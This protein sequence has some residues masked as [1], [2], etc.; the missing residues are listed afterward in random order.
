M[1]KPK[2]AQKNDVQKFQSCEFVSFFFYI[3]FLVLLHLHG[4]RYLLYIQ[5]QKQTNKHNIRNNN[6][7]NN[8]KQVKYAGY[9]ILI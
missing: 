6:N 8:K 7:N 1:K 3:Y 2:E 4:S 9:F 5:E